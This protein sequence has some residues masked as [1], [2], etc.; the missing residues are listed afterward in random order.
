MSGILLAMLLLH[1]EAI[2]FFAQHGLL[3]QWETYLLPMGLITEAMQ[4]V[5]CSSASLNDTSPIVALVSG[6]YW[7]VIAWLVYAGLKRRK[8]K[9]IVWA[10]VGYIGCVALA[11]T[12]WY[13]ILTRGMLHSAGDMFPLAI[14]VSVLYWSIMTGFYA[15]LTRHRNKLV[16][17]G[18]VGYIGLVIVFCF[19]LGLHFNMLGRV[20]VHAK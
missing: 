10:I 8:Y 2:R 16:I 5:I 6:L 13:L 15:G 9:F 3:G 4:W 11:M 1:A 14:L 19:L 17:W 20:G 18:I 7:S 12:M